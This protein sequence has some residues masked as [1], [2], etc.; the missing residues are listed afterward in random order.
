[1][2]MSSPKAAADQRFCWTKWVHR[3]VKPPRGTLQSVKTVETRAPHMTS[4]YTANCGSGPD[5]Q[6]LWPLFV[7][8]TSAGEMKGVCNAPTIDDAYVHEI[9]ISYLER[10][11]AMAPKSKDIRKFWPWLLT[12]TL[13]LGWWKGYAICLRVVVQIRIKV[14]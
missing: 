11:K 2:V 13:E 5:K 10:F 14:R 4:Y 12:L 8:L 6:R 3:F 1:M 9:S 7:I